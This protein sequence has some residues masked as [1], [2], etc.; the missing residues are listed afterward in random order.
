M[1]PN[2]VTSLEDVLSDY[3]VTDTLRCNSHAGMQATRWALQDYDLSVH[4]GAFSGLLRLSAQLLPAPPPGAV[5]LVQ[6]R[7]LRDAAMQLSDQGM[8]L[9]FVGKIWRPHALLQLPQAADF[10]SALR[11]DSRAA[12]VVW[13]LEAVS[14]AP[15]ER[16]QLR[17][18]MRLRYPQRRLERMVCAAYWRGVRRL[19]A[20]VRLQLLQSVAAHARRAP[21]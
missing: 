16:A 14:D 9:G 7:R 11:R 20:H 18:V 21:S 5:R 19:S 10:V 17:L 8:V 1:S 13:S 2:Q 3:D 12:G 15:Q 6:L 4:A